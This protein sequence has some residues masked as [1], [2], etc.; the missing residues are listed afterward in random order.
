MKTRT[1]I[2]ITAA[3][4]GVIGVLIAIGTSAFFSD[5]ETSDVNIAGTGQISISDNNVYFSPGAILLRPLTSLN[6]AHARNNTATGTAVI[7]HTGTVGAV[8]I[9][10]RQKAVGGTVLGSSG[11]VT[12]VANPS[13][14]ALD[15]ALFNY[16][17]LCIDDDGAYD[18]VS[19]NDC[20]VYGGLNGMG[21]GTG[22]NDNTF[23]MDPYA[24]GAELFDG[25]TGLA[26]ESSWFPI[27]TNV[28]NS[29]SATV[30]F[31][32]WMEDDPAVTDNDY[33]LN[34]A[35]AVFEVEAN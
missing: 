33:Q 11:G 34:Q 29:G 17:R 6:A 7:T 10:I 13:G 24:A 23:D 4:V 3:A 21:G 20:D 22:A 31:T 12:D 2:L 28:P 1:K 18:P 5:T 9:R 16:L 32:V 14:A 30:Y 15:P 27:A 25:Q 19:N 8:D 35:A 26:G